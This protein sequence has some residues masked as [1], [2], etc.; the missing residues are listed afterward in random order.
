MDKTYEIL[1]TLSLLPGVPGQEK[2]VRAYIKSS[3]EGHADEFIVD[4]LGSL[5]AIKKH[6]GPKVMIAGHMDEVG[7]LVTQITKDGFVKFQTLG[8]WFSQV[9]L[10]QVWD[11][12]TPKGVVTAV[13]GVKP[14]HIIPAEKRKEAISIESMYLDIGVSSKEEALAL[15]VLPGQMVTPHSEFKVLGSGKHLLSKAWDNR[16][17]SAV[18]MEVLKQLDQT[19]NELFATFTVQEEVGLRGA[20][21][22]SY[23]AHPEIAIA[24]DTGLAND[25]PEGDKNEQSLG[26]GPQILLYDGGLVPNQNLR[27]FVIEVAK[28]E[29]IPYQEAFITGGRTDAGNMHLAHQGALGLSIGIPT[30]YMHSHTSIIHYDDYENTVKLVLAV[31]K[32][33]DRQKV[34][35]L[36]NN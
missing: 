20:K 10:A 25:V 19:P 14:P 22:S 28:E 11:I 5:I 33:L 29:G 16:I 31:V 8:G 18:V 1:K 27:R 26:K 3:L 23:V 2:K 4:N 17:G 32:K 13:T 36:L 7:L 34:D 24:V 15:G 12:H 9:M 30:R 21:T 6:D 35:E